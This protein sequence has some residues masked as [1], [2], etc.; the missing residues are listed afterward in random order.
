MTI[1]KGL[2]G[3]PKFYLRI[4]GVTGC[5]TTEKEVAEVQKNISFNNFPNNQKEET[6]K[7]RLYLKVLYPDSVHKNERKLQDY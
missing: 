2:T 4:L 1:T 3:L 5:I 6:R 7:L